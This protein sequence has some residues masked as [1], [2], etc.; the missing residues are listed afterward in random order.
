MKGSLTGEVVDGDGLLE[1]R[2]HLSLGG[3][4]HVRGH[5]THFLQEGGKE[6]SSV[7]KNMVARLKRKETAHMYV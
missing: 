3:G 4:A 7:E 5:S 6:R 2:H 1:I